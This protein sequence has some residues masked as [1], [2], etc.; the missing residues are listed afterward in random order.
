MLVLLHI[1]INLKNQ[2]LINHPNYKAPQE[3]VEGVALRSEVPVPGYR[4]LVLGDGALVPGDGAP[5]LGDGALVLGDEALVPGDGASVPGDGALVPGD[6]AL[7]PGED[8]H[9]VLVNDHI[10]RKEI[11]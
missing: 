4:V 7:V 3:A 1:A 9:L 6:G 2:C 10:H 11:K 5:V 8:G